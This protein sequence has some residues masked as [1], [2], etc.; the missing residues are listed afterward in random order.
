MPSDRPNILLILTDMQ[1]HDTIGA[2]GNPV[3]KTPQIDRLCAEGT[4]FTRCYTPSPVCVPARCSLHYGRYPQRTGCT[5]NMPMPL[6]PGE[7]YPER[8]S[9]AG[10]RTR[11]IGKCHFTPADN[12]H[13]FDV[14]ESQEE[15]TGNPANDDYLRHLQAQGYDH[16]LDPHGVRGEMYYVPQVAAM[17]QELHPTHWVGDRACAFIDEQADSGQP[18]MLKASFIHP[19]PPFNPPNPWHKLYRSPRMPL[20]RFPHD[21]EAHLTHG[22]RVQ[23][24]YKYRDQGF[25]FQLLRQIKASYYACIS[26]IDFQIGRILD[27]L[28]ASGQLENTLVVFTSDHGEHLGDYGC[29]GKR[30]M[31]DTSSRV[32]L[33]VRG[34]GFEAGARCEHPASLVDIAPTMCAHAGAEA[35]DM[36]GLRLDEMARGRVERDY[37]FSQHQQGGLAEYLIAGREACYFYSAAD[38]REY[39]YDQRRDPHQQQLV[40]VDAPHGAGLL[41]PLRE[42]LQAHLRQ[43]GVDEAL[44]AES[45][46]GWQRYPAQSI[47]ATP[48]AGLLTQDHWWAI[49]RQWIPGYS[50]REEFLIPLGGDAERFRQAFPGH[51]AVG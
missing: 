2:L 28:A 25:D 38:D 20:P 12:L 39:G 10:Y 4:A 30:S 47:S 7:S 41:R 16:V 9:A 27:A 46:H 11:A 40:A 14:R 1:R 15:V 23:N 17:P 36:D 43:S 3:I 49:P 13:G 18:W 45:A 35:G 34:P 29:F 8:L 21:R 51:P 42:R 26:F 32:P 50:E 19:H 48:D 22:N 44:D 31:H 6:F 33:I 24:R 37:V 5:H